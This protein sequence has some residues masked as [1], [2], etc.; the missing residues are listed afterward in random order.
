M[1]ML[2][3]ADI[4]WLKSELVPALA[5]AVQKKL[6]KKLDNISTKLAITQPHSYLVRTAA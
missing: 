2:T 5:D 4:D 6:E 1:S 3:K